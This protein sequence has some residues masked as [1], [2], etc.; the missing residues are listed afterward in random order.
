MLYTL[1]KRLV[2]R[3]VLTDDELRDIIGRSQGSPL[4][5]EDLLT[6]R[7]IA[8]HELLHCLTERFPLPCVEFDESVI[9]SPQ[10][11][12][13]IDAERL[14]DRLWFPLS[15]GPASAQ[16]IAC[17]PQDPSVLDD[18]RR[19]LGVQQVDLLS[20]LPSDLIRI[21]EHN[22]DINPGFPPAAGRTPLAKVRTF[23]A[24]RRSLFAC[25][26][27]TLARGRTGLALLRTG[28]SFIAIAVALLKLFGV[29]RASLL[30]VPLLL[31]GVVMAADGFR[32]YLPARRAAKQHPE[33]V[34]TTATNGTTVLT[35]TWSGDAPHFIRS[36]PVA[37][38][39]G[40]RSGWDRLS[41]VMRRRLLASDRTDLAEERTVLAGIRTRMA[42]A[43]TGL[44]F[45]RTGIAFI[46][47]G[48][49]LFRYE[50]IHGVFWT[51]FDAALILLGLLA[52]IE[53]LGWYVPG[54]A[55]GA[56][57]LA[58]V[59]AALERPNIWESLFPPGHKRTEGGGAACRPRMT[60]TLAPGIWA[61]TGLALER[62]V[63]AERRNVMARLRTIMAR[64][65]TG[66]AFVRTGMSISAVGA[67]LL[68]AFGLSSAAWTVLDVL[69]IAAGLFFIGDGMA[70]HLPAE[71]TR[72]QYPYCYCDVEITMPDYGRPACSWPTAVFSHDDL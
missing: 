3:R 33:A 66:L 52:I 40:L 4:R 35:A 19:S 17:D 69:L 6:S 13:R 58:S 7:G 63:L 29:S 47:L 70:W 10:V 14:K 27:T 2:R 51:V 31:S 64:S 16:V 28:M 26:R 34:P 12:R 1:Y 50:R 59:R 9:V 48:I 38:A 41:P 54:R 21:I 65:R 44:A 67:G 56:S 25:T 37:G 49:A 42:R 18:V 36:A 71:R 53:G 55:A 57:G 11:M 32:R 60:A 39:A 68:V 5:T 30:Q 61:T 43:R 46:G 23:L 24:D 15:V 22:Q 62:T 20:A 72:M 45:T 8:K